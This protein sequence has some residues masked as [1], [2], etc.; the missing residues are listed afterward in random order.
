M[1]ILLKT[2]KDQKSGTELKFYS[3]SFGY[4]LFKFSLTRMG[5]TG[6]FLVPSLGSISSLLLAPYPLRTTL[7][8]H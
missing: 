7:A 5:L 2:S 8:S 3:S 1:E 4:A 6:P